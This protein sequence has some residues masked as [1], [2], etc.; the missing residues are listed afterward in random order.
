MMQAP[1]LA[2]RKI[3]VNV[4]TV[5]SPRVGNEQFRKFLRLQATKLRRDKLLRHYRVHLENDIVPSVPPRFLG[6]VHV[7]RVVKFVCDEAGY[8]RDVFFKGDGT[9]DNEVESSEVKGSTGLWQVPEGIKA[10]AEYITDH[11]LPAYHKGVGQKQKSATFHQLSFGNGVT[12]PPART[13][14]TQVQS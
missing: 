12:V 2:D 3:K 10:Q 7:G 5:G 9:D 11:G 14:E 1:D 4:F 13:V 6:F 8:V